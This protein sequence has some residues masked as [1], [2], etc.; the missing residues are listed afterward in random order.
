MALFCWLRR[1]LIRVFFKHT[2]ACTPRCGALRFA[3][4]VCATNLAAVYCRH[5]ANDI[6]RHLRAVCVGIWLNMTLL[7][8]CLARRLAGRLV[9]F[10]SDAVAHDAGFGWTRRLHLYLLS[11]ILRTR[12]GVCAILGFLFHWRPVMH[13]SWTTPHQQLY[14]FVA[15]TTLPTP[16]SL[17]GGLFCLP[18]VL[19]R[20]Y[21]VR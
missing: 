15:C 2:T 13:S 8:F 11:F 16:S 21:S 5:S 6:H 4:V 10:D 7:P 9:R 19:L 17:L 14:P 18:A 20:I 1:C 3:D 12:G